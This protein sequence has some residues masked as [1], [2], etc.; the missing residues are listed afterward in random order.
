MIDLLCSHYIG[1]GL[2]DDPAI[3]LVSLIMTF[4]P[5]IQDYLIVPETTKETK[6]LPYDPFSGPKLDEIETKRITDMVDDK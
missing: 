2:A 4:G 3:E 5:M 1:D 6:K